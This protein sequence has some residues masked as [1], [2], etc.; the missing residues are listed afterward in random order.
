[1]EFLDQDKLQFKRG[2]IFPGEIGRIGAANGSG[3]ARLTENRLIL[4][5]V[6]TRRPRP[7]A[8]G[9]TANEAFGVRLHHTLRSS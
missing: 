5:I 3:W 7:R 4:P 1:M 8:A 6:H 2:V 9:G